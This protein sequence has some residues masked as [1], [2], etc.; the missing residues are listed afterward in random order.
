M[1]MTLRAGTGGGIADVSNAA[2]RAVLIA[3]LKFVT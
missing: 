1:I 2:K 3:N